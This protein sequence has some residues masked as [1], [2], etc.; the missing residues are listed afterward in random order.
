MNLDKRVREQRLSYPFLNLKI[1]KNQTQIGEVMSQAVISVFPEDR[2]V[3][4][5]EIFDKNR[6]HHLPVVDTMGIVQGILSKGDIQR[7]EHHFTLFNRRK[8][9]EVNDMVFKSIS[10]KDIMTKEVA[11]V[12]KETTIET[13]LGY[14]RENLF[15]A[16]PVIDT[17]GKL[18]GMLTT[19]DLLMYAYKS[20]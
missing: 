8:S 7:L 10:A 4:I 9:Q 16:L 15:R 13:A 5:K 1:M 2:L 14:F 11:T 6:F 19:F 18:I 17:A 20:E 3:K 12:E